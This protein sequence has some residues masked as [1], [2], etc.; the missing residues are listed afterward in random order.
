MH[1]VLDLASTRLGDRILAFGK[2]LHAVGAAL[3]F[4]AILI[5]LIAIL[6]TS[7]FRNCTKIVEGIGLG[8]FTGL[9]FS[10]SFKWCAIIGMPDMTL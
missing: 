5:N 3:I 4:V 8:V 2:Y 10:R 6:V 9:F 1:L 7:E